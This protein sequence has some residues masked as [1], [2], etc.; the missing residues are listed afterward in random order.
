MLTKT[1][2]VWFRR[3]LRLAD[4]PALEHAARGG[5]VVPVF[6]TEWERRDPWATGEAGRWWLRLSLQRLAADLAAR[7]VPLLL[8]GGDPEDV[9]PRL[10]A[11]QGAAEVVW[12]RLYEPYARR[13]EGR[14]EAA[15]RREAV[16]TR[17]FEAA[18]LF[19]PES[20]RSRSGRP[21]V[22]FG[23]FWRSCLALPE[24]SRPESPPPRLVGVGVGGG[25]LGVPTA[26]AQASPS[27][28][29]TAL[30]QADGPGGSP[31]LKDAAP[32]EPGEAG[33]Q[34]RLK[35]FLAEALAGYQTGRDL[36]GVEGVSR[37]SPHLHFGDIGPRQVW[38]AVRDHA[39]GGGGLGEG[40][41]A[42]LRQLGWRE[43]AHYLLYHFPETPT[44]PFRPEFARFPW[45]DDPDALAAWQA[46]KTG[47][48]LVDAGMRQLA[49]EGWMHNR[50][51]MVV[52]SF[53]T[54]DL[55]V[56]WQLGAAWFWD[57]L[58]DADLANNTLG[59]QWTAGCGP[60]A[61]PY[62]RVYNPLLQARRFDP[63]GAYVRRWSAPAAR[64]GA[65][66]RAA[67]SL[68]PIVDHAEARARAL[69]AFRGLRSL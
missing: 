50:V 39:A 52:A 67:D 37:L 54:K 32:W 12:N 21:F 28:L 48:P 57:H 38:H 13:L 43:F 61:A 18:L 68:T 65:D 10:A 53:L 69:A 22:Q 29:S 46:G 33:A 58:V 9:L 8:L 64:A 34:T 25:H 20:Q 41:A 17:G 1:T 55:L 66:P 62:F 30:E 5:R 31:S 14:V 36:P 11:Q 35:R 63:E 45:A 42:F 16:A 47:F 3:D 40:A 59:W 4:N 60:D 2:I 7:G 26:V 19:E 6:L 15:L 44:E 49:A 24:P 56:P 51:R 23:A 27:P